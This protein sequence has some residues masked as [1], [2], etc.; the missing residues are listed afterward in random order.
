MGRHNE[1]HPQPPPRP[2]PDIDPR[3]GALRH[4][5]WPSWYRGPVLRRQ[6]HGLLPRRPEHLPLRRGLHTHETHFRA[7]YLGRGHRG[8]HSPTDGL[9]CCRRT[10]HHVGLLAGA[11][12]RGAQCWG[13]A[14]GFVTRGLAAR[15]LH[16][17]V[18]EHPARV[19][20]RWAQDAVL[21]EPRAERARGA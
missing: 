21:G 7:E 11:A 15:T 19:P 20:R 6:P 18:L 17:P 8:R 12:P 4:P 10:I 2:R 9:G 16:V 13:L 14:L 5:L 1:P 3:R